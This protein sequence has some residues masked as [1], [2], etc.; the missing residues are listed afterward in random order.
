MLAMKALRVLDEYRRPP[1]PRVEVPV[2]EGLGCAATEAPRGLLYHRYEIDGEGLIPV[3]QNR[4]APRKIRGASKT[5]SGSSFPG[6]PA[7][8][9]GK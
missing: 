3:G 8:L 7:G 6:W 4:P 2:R 5:I 1:A 9:P